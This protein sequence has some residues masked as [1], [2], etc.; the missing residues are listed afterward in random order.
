M[1][2]PKP[3]YNT[4]NDYYILHNGGYT[5]PMAGN[6]LYITED[7]YYLIMHGSEPH[8]NLID[9][10]IYRKNNDASYITLINYYLHLENYP[11]LGILI[12]SNEIYDPTPNVYLG[13]APQHLGKANYKSILDFYFYGNL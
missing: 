5:F 11:I 9:G 3:I 10:L 7:D 12:G 13:D 4:T 1:L 6:E 2:I 8:D